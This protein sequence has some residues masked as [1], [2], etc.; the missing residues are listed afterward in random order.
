MCLI[1]LSLRYAAF[2][3]SALALVTL[4]LRAETKELL[5]AHLGT[6]G[7][8]YDL[9]VNEFARRVNAKLPPEYKVV[10][11][12]NSRLGRDS[13]VL[14]K[15]KTGEVAFGLP[16]S[17]MSSISP[18]FNVFELP[19]LIGNREQVRKLGDA[20]LEPVFQP[21]AKKAGFRILAMWENG[22]RQITNNMRPIKRPEDLKGL[23]IRAP[24]TGSWRDKVFRALGAEPVAVDFGKVYEGLQAGTIEGQQNPLSLI[25]A[26]EFYKVQRYLSLSDHLY[27]PAY[28]I[29]SERHFTELPPQVQEVLSQTAQ[30]L[31]SWIF[32]SAIK[33]ESDLVDQVGERMQINQ[34]DLHAFRRA[35][36]PIYGEFARTVPGGA[37]LIETINELAEMTSSQIDVR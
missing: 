13:A 1:S 21:E 28:L 33:L 22:F 26:T 3:L 24:S 34:I 6:P 18:K 31:Q 8:I 37:R 7:S 12:G 11:A 14:E 5:L 9:S 35:S 19:F 25:T 16:S 17:A 30:E 2:A 10:P 20:L 29:V 15:L 32:D 4:P 27:T 23:K 36:R